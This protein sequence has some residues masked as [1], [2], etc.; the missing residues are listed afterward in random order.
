MD[1]ILTDSSLDTRI[2]ICILM[3]V[4]ITK[5]ERAGEVWEGYANV[6]K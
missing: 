1:T 2:K 6:V 5:L 3:N 4:I